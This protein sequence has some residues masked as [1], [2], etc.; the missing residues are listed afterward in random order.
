MR[1]AWIGPIG[2]D[3][4]VGSLGTILLRG[5]LEEGAE[6]DFFTE[7]NVKL[8]QSL[9][10]LRNLTVV[11]SPTW[12][13]WDKWYSRRSIT[14]FIS[15]ML[16]RSQSH[17]RACGMILDRHRHRPYDC[18]FQFSQAEIFKLASNL[19]KLPPIVI[20]P[21]VH[22]AGELLWHRR[23]SS[24][25]IQSEGRLM[26]YGV[27]LM[28]R[29]RTAV[30][31]R[32]IQ[33]PSMILGLSQ[34]FN[35]LLTRD[36]GVPPERLHVL[37]HAIR[38]AGNDSIGSNDSEVV[39]ISLKLLFVARISVRKGFEQI[40]ELSRR[41]DDL[42]G[43]VTIDIIGDKTQWSDYT[44]HIKE[45]NFRIANH[46]GSVSHREMGSIYDTSDILLVPSM[47]EP[48]GLV[49]GEALSR[50]VSVVASDEVGSAEPISAESCRRFPAGN[51]DALEA[52]TRELIAE[53]RKNRVGLR[54]CAREQAK[55]HFSP[56]IASRRL[57]TLLEE[58]A[59]KSSLWRGKE[60]F[61][62][63]AQ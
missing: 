9:L 36:Y 12:W 17:G 35:E 23:E 42:H 10:L 27:R 14:A 40:V 30:Q 54:Q 59:P 33:L 8:P 7:E 62:L 19:D 61:S 6:V 29:Y 49:V 53:I 16:A 20:Y 51:V 58:A 52:A 63:A 50:G 13:R 24:Y 25:A 2:E 31:R 43:Q 4:G 55:K 21:C 56:E 46:V 32:Q 47:Y 38:D 60:K 37:Y 39:P 3:G 15:G 26:H 18:I 44:G 5:V 11:R 34:R 57:L 45:L 28:L 48:G 22:A 41:L 1:I